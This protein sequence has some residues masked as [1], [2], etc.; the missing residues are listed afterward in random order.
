MSQE[1]DKLT[2]IET[3]IFDLDNTLYAARHNLFDQVAVRITDFVSDFLELERDHAHTIQKQ[4]F[5]DHGTTLNGLVKLH[6]CN[7]DEFLAYVHDV[8]YSPIPPD[9]ELDNALARLPGRKLIFT[10]GDVP[11]AER[12]MERLGVGHHF[13]SVFDIVASDYIPK[14]EPVVYDVLVDLHGIDPTRAVFFEDMARNLKPAKER[15]MATVWIE[16]ESSYAK[17]GADDGFIDFRAPELTPWL[18]DLA[19]HLEET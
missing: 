9:P 2:T 1:L 17:A 18:V 19:L 5:L 6:D 4:Y 12:A 3:W 7:P 8:D 15:G 11:H 14:P 13:E 10:N 16:G